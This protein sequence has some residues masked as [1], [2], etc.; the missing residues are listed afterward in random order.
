MLAVTAPASDLPLEGYQCC[1]FS[2]ADCNCHC[3]TRCDEGVVIREVVRA[4]RPS[5]K[6]HFPLP[7]TKQKLMSEL[8]SHAGCRLITFIPAILPSPS[9]ETIFVF[10]T[11]RHIF[12]NCV[13]CTIP[14]DSNHKEYHCFLRPNQ[15]KSKFYSITPSQSVKCSQNILYCLTSVWAPISGLR[16]AKHLVTP[17]RHV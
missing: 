16:S 14:P 3:C 8:S 5:G 7:N 11:D 10:T 4:T 1:S 12:G 15:I 6:S 2:G 13:W 17:H 9:L